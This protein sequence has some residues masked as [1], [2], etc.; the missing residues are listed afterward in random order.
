M[1]MPFDEDSA[2]IADARHWCDKL[3]GGQF[4]GDYLAKMAMS[5]FLLMPL[6]GENAVER[7]VLTEKYD[8]IAGNMMMYGRNLCAFMTYDDIASTDFLA[9]L[10]VV[11]SDRI[12][13]IGFSMG[14]YRAWMLA[15]LSENCR[16]CICLLDGDNRCADDMEVRT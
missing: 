8:I 16:M 7:K 4:F 11:D 3:Y 14:A 5:C 1:I 10:N 9:S 15:A 12:G 6:Y 13:C 2:V